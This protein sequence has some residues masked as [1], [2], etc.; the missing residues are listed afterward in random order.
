MV[1]LS[2]QESIELRETRGRG[3]G[4]DDGDLQLR[5]TGH[6]YHFKPNGQ[7]RSSY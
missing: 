7:L 5:E 4:V 1:P 6:V 2:L 3:E